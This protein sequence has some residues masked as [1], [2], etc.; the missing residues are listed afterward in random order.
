MGGLDGGNNGI[1]VIPLEVFF[2]HHLRV[3]NAPTEV[4]LAFQ[5]PGIDVEDVV[6]SS[7][8]DSVAANLIARIVGF[9]ADMTVELVA[10]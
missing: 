10:F 9:L 5:E 8:A 7:V 3:F 4:I 6:H 1:V 2:S